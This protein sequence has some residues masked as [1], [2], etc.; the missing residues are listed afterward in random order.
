[1][2]VITILVDNE[3]DIKFKG[4]LAVSTVVDNDILEIYVT[5]GGNWIIHI[6]TGA[7]ES[8]ASVYSNF[9]DCYNAIVD[10]YSFNLETL[11]NIRA[12]TTNTQLLAALET[13]LVRWID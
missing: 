13:E 9:K 1:M 3:P 2:G 10:D 4:E 11:K 6:V 8:M 12:S 7:D 5:V